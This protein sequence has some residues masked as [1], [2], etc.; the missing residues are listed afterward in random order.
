MAPVS[1]SYLKAL[2]TVGCSAQ[3]EPSQC[4][5]WERGAFEGALMAVTLIRTLLALNGQGPERLDFLHCTGQL[6]TKSICWC[7]T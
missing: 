2:H 4:S 5:Y 3:N 1:G 6:C 7:P